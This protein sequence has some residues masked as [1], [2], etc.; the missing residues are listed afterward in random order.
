MQSNKMIILLLLAVQTHCVHGN[1]SRIMNG[2]K[3][4]T[5]VGKAVE[6]AVKL[7][8]FVGGCVTAYHET[9]Y[10]DAKHKHNQ[11]P[12]DGSSNSATALDL[13]RTMEKHEKSAYFTQFYRFWQK[14]RE[15][16]DSKK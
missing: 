1:G 15:N 2:L 3:N 11:L 6:T 5:E 9:N 12:K 7:A 10:H 4:F 16:E 14:M 13:K 8:A